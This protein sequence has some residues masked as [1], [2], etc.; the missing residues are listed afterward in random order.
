MKNVLNKSGL[1]TEMSTAHSSRYASTSAA[2]R[3]GVN[4][5]SIRKTARST[6]NSMT[7]TKFY[8]LQVIEDKN[9]F[10]KAVLKS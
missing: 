6:A 2:K 4:I 5:D 3:K 1:D 10:A 8:D 9:A 7:F